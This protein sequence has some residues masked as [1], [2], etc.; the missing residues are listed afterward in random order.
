MK[1]PQPRRPRRG[2]SEWAELVEKS[3]TSS[4]SPSEFCAQANVSLSQLYHWRRRLRSVAAP[5]S[6]GFSQVRLRTPAHPSTAASAGRIEV[7]LLSGRV[8]HVVGA[9]DPQA[10]REVILTAE[11]GTPC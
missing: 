8:V 6:G 9:V 10:L 11:A 1:T 5:V 3:K 4:L 2:A 7:H